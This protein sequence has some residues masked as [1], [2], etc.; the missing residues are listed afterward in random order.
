[1][2]WRHWA[3]ALAAVVAF[4]ALLSLSDSLRLFKLPPLWVR[5]NMYGLD[6]LYAAV[7]LLAFL[8]VDRVEPPAPMR[9]YALALLFASVACGILDALLSYWSW[10]YTPVAIRFYRGFFGSFPWA[11]LVVML[12]LRVRASQRLAEELQHTQVE[13]AVEAARIAGE[14]VESLESRFDAHGLVESIEAAA[15][16]Y[17]RDRMQGDAMLD[18]LTT[19]LRAAAAKPV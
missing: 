16:A 5:M 4:N 10:P 8:A 1:M 6:V 9:R 14:R 13:G 19:R 12:A 11:V 15:K 2:T 7:Q 18:A 3:W 17:A